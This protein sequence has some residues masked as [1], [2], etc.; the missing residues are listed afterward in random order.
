[1]S[2]WLHVAMLVLVLAH[3]PLL[4][5]VKT[6]T[7]MPCAKPGL[8]IVRA[9]AITDG[10]WFKDGVDNHKRRLALQAWGWSPL[11]LVLNVSTHQ[12]L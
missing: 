8:K 2:C 6:C 12:L 7:Y 4:G 10:M 3:M 9:W 5:R 1:M 11:P